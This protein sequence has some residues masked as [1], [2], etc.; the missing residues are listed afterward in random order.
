VL[1]GV[2]F[3]QLGSQSVRADAPACSV[4][5]GAQN[6]ITVA[7]SHGQAFY[8][9]TGASPKL[10]AGYI[11][12]RITNSTGSTQS[13]LWTEASSFTGGVLGLANSMDRYQQVATLTNNSTAASYFLLKASSATA[14]PQTHHVKVWNGRP[15]LPGSQALY[16]CIYTFSAVKE[17]IKAAANKVSDTGYGTTAAIEVS[18]T[19]PELGQT[20]VISVEGTTG[21][22]GAGSSPDGSVVWLTPA[23]ISSWPT[24]ALRLENVSVTFERNTNNGQKW[25]GSGDPVTYTNQLLISNAQ[26]CLK[27]NANVSTCTGGT[28]SASPE[29][30]AFYTFRVVGVPSSSVKSV[31]VAQIASGTQIKHA[32]TTATGATVDINFS[33]VNITASLTKS[34]TNTTGLQT[35]TCGGSCLVPG[36]V[37]GETYAAVPYRLTG[38]STSATAISIDEIVDQPQSGVIY[39]PG[40]ARITDIGRTNVTIDD[41]SYLDSEASVIPRPIHFVGPFNLSLSTTASLNYEMWVPVGSSTNTAYA[42]VGDLLIGATASA[43]S[44]VVVTSDGSGTVGA[45]TTTEEL[46][47]VAATQPATNIT[48][49]TATINGTVDPNGANPL[50]ATFE[51]ATNANV[52]GSTTVTAT[53]PAGGNVGGLSIPTNVSYS[54]S[55]LSA[56]TTYYYRIVAGSAQGTTLSFTTNAIVAPPTVTTASATS[57]TS[58]GATLNGT[59][60]PNLTSVLA[61][62]FIYSTSPTLASGNI[63]LTLDDGAGGNL[64]ASGSSTQ[65]FSTTVTGLSNGT[66][67]YYKLRGCTTSNCSSFVDGSIVNFVAQNPPSNP[68]LSVT[69]MADDGDGIV[70]PGQGVTYTITIANS[71][72]VAG[73]TSFTDTIPTGMGAPTNFTYTN[74]G[75]PSSGYIA[76]TLTLSTITVSTTNNCIVTYYVTIA[77]PLNQGT[78]LTNSVDVA[79]AIQGGNNPAPVS[80]NTLT[81]DATPDLSTSSKSVN[82]ANGGTAEPGDTLS[83]TITLVN[84]GD[85]RGTGIG[86]TDTIDSDTQNITNVSQANC[87]SSTNNST[88]SQLNVTGIAVAVG[89]NCVI[90]FDVTV[91]SPLSEGTAISNTAAISAASEGGLGATPTS[92]IIYAD[93]TPA[94]VVSHSEDD[95]DNIVSPDQAVTYTI[96]IQNTGN[97]Q[98]TGISAASTV[99][100]NAALN[101]GSVVFTDCGSPGD[102]STSSS[103][104][105][106]NIHVDADGTCTITYDLIVKTAAANGATVASNVDIGQASQGGNNPAPVSANTLTVS[107]AIIPPDSLGFRDGATDLACNGISANRSLRLV[108]DS[109]TNVA[110]YEV[111]LNGGSAISTGT[112]TY[113]DWTLPAV[114]GDHTFTVRAV[115]S[116]NN[117]SSWSAACAVTL[118]QTTPTVNAGSD[119]IK[120]SDFV[121]NDSTASDGTAGIASYNWTKVSGPGL[122]SFT[123]AS[124]LHPDVSASVDGT[125]VLQLT[126]T[127]NAGNSASDTF[128]LIWDT[129]GPTVDA[130]TNQNASTSFTQTTATATDAGSGISSYSWSKLSG[131][132]GIIFTTASGLH[133]VIS[134][135]ADDT[136]VL[137]LFVTDVAG[138]TASDTFT[139]VWST[140]VPPTNDDDGATGTEEQAAPNQGDA[141]NDGQPDADQKNVTSFTNAVTNT[142]AVLE[143]TNNCQNVN[144]SQHAMNSLDK[145][146]GA[147]TYPAGLMDFTLVC[148]SPGATV[149]VNQYFY[150]IST[151]NLVARKYDSR[152]NTYIT[153]TTAEISLVTIGG[154]QAVKIAY[155]ITDGGSLDEDGLVNGSIVDPSGPA[156]LSTNIGVPNTGLVRRPLLPSLFYCVASLG[157]VSLVL[158]HR[159]RDCAMHR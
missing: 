17:T 15:D 5:A 141:N 21:T 121:Q 32:D 58:S 102:A 100:S 136:Y 131:S 109:A 30:R 3:L 142:Y 111:S 69:K 95:A 126:V 19:N 122:V 137:Q 157:A 84:T 92:T 140:P 145:A 44:K 43:M 156:V 54:F 25:T 127:D 41:P 11:G 6:G 135:D 120:R 50:V 113:Y 150:G 89:T 117:R 152:T 46:G 31:P 72:G 2:V 9:D 4:G 158:R 108:W 1:L 68:V 143:N 34:V 78:T 132:G 36:G 14:T 91:K 124:D 81:V 154:Q 52:T 16:D 33:G 94:L 29:Y 105:F 153:I 7:P 151:T 144:V 65:S 86:V 75:S 47:V 66:S 139:L 128:T 106:S 70:T 64:T 123:D 159:F 129:T 79:A 99:S 98:A 97:G 55:G 116:L 39:K 82:D 114:D 77:S 37:N 155:D 59:I 104:S 28:G 147:Y 134:A 119:R 10:D 103:L 67:Y 45:V 130:G 90:T 112:N 20:I 61:I 83:Y 40:S 71:G 35:V 85:G 53:T 22:I 13:D 49:S 57:I 23:A 74:C 62:Q 80:A 12:Y 60:N 148:S 118:D 18:N 27:K 110:S 42:K 38:T 149:R 133:P 146:D 101:V 63:T 138:N 107:T 125:Y 76:P 26:N 87:G 51:Y 88:G 93:V 8:I 48:T 115:D 56:N 24:R 96:T 73:T